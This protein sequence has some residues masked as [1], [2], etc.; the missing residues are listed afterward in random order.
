MGAT[1]TYNY[2]EV[3]VGGNHAGQGKITLNLAKALPATAT[4]NL[5]TI[6]GSV[7]CSIS[8]VVTTVFSATSTHIS[9]GVTGNTTALAAPPGS[10]IVSIAVGSTLIL[11]TPLG[12]ALPAPL[13]ASGTAAGNTAVL[14]E[15][16][17][18]IITVTTDATNTGAITWTLDWYP[19]TS[20]AS[21]TAD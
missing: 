1:N 12:A 21:V 2:R 5:F 19:L 13:V 18:T 9:I 20:G 11:P 14:V 17:N 16:A 3:D 4:G 10:G 15:L 8:G 7:I 6:A